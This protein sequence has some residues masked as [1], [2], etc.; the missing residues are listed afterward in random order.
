MTGAEPA[1]E[2]L[3]FYNLRRW[4]KSKNV[5]LTGKYN[6]GLRDLGLNTFCAFHTKSNLRLLLQFLKIIQYLVNGT[7]LWRIQYWSSVSEVGTILIH[8]AF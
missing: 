8:I 3:F 1:P 5:V 4:T 2:T 6:F 7:F